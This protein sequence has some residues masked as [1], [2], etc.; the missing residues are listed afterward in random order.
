MTLINATKSFDFE[1]KQGAQSLR[2]ISINDLKENDFTFVID[3]KVALML[4]N[5]FN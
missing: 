4:K 3:K 2:W 1:M 5:K